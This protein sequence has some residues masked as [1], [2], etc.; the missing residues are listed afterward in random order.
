LLHLGREIFEHV[1]Q[2]AL[3]HCLH[4]V[5]QHDRSPCRPL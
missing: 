1:G 5:G 4:R 3:E 2:H